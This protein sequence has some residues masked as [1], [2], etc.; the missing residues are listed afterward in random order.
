MPSSV[1]RIPFPRRAFTVG[2][3]LLAAACGGDASEE[4]ANAGS[5]DPASPATA[6]DRERAAFTPPADSTLVPRQVEAFLRTTLVQFDLVRQ[7]APRYQQKVA[8]MEQRA[9]EGGIVAG[10]RNAADAGSVMVGFGDLVGGSFVRSA[11]SQG[12]NPA[13]MEWVRDRMVEVSAHLALRPLHQGMIDQAKAVRTQAQ[14]YRGQPGWDEAAI[15]QMLQSADEMEREGQA[16]MNA[17]AT[18]RRNLEV[19]RRARPNVTDPMWTAVALA[20]SAGGLVGLH[21][22]AEPG[23]TTARRQMDEWRRVYTDALADKVTPGMEAGPP[24]AD[25]VPVTDATTP[26][27]N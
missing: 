20:G 16:Q 22:L 6:T 27:S 12:L 3:L 11:R 23:D 24:A 8:Q 9:K 19:L 1:P 7:E 14:Q 5:V 10:L 2:L 21:G 15:Q 4:D 17:S 13:E 25:A 26:P 18:V